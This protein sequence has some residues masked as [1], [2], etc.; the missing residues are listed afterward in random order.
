MRRARADQAHLEILEEDKTLCDSTY[1]VS[2]DG[3]PTT[4]VLSLGHIIASGGEGSIFKY[5]KI[6][7]CQFDVFS[8]LLF[9][10]WRFRTR[11]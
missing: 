6:I 1:I 8:G 3:S 10:C 7:N 9:S 4:S 11:F 5:E 2:P